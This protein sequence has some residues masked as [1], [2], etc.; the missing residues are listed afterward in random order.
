MFSLLVDS[1]II[2]SNNSE[3]IVPK[4]YIDSTT[5]SMPDF[6]FPRTAKIIHR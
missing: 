2:A 1:P 5:S 4:Y 6:S 3:L